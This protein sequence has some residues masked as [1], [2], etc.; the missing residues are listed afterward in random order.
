LGMRTADPESAF[1]LTAKEGARLAALRAE[2]GV[3]FVPENQRFN[4]R[5]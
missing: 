5:P 3:D 1:A 2:A 4:T